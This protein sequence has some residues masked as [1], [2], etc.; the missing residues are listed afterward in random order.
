[1]LGG[2]IHVLE[3]IKVKNIIISK[4]KQSNEYLEKILEITQAKMINVIVVKAGDKINLD[5]KTYFDILWPD[6][7]LIENNSTNNNSI[8]TNLVFD[9]FKILFTGD[10]EEIAENEIVKKY[11]NTNRLKCSILKIPH[12][13]SKTSTTE[14]FLKLVNP[15]IGLIGVGKDN[16]FNHPN[17]EVLERL[18]KNG[19]KIYRTDAN[20]EIRI[21]VDTR[22]RIKI[23]KFKR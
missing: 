17:I 15:Q 4:Q 6:S 11:K 13:G 10:V 18:Q 2:I 3:N 22:M 12:H 16:K 20:G 1:M 23:K 21:I 5:E 19:S 14:E 7:N 8:V 9:E